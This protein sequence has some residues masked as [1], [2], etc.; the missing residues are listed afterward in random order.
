MGQYLFQQEILSGDE[1]QK[2]L[3]LRDGDIPKVAITYKEPLYHE[4]GNIQEKAVM[5][6]MSI[7]DHIGIRDPLKEGGIQVRVEGHLIKEDIWIEDLLGEDIP[8]GMEGLLEEEDILEEDP[9]MVEG[10][11]MEMED[12]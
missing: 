8:I 3:D 12:P 1:C 6:R 7:E 5:M 10:P 11:L 4:E 9:L 2:I